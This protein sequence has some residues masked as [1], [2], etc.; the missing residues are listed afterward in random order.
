MQD[1]INLYD[2]WPILLLADKNGIYLYSM[3]EY[4][5]ARSYHKSL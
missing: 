5:K 2:L 4:D 3:D 1:N